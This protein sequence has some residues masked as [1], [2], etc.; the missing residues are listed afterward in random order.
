MNKAANENWFLLRSFFFLDQILY[1]KSQ[2]GNAGST[3]FREKPFSPLEPWKIHGTTLQFSFY[4]I[5]RGILRYRNNGCLHTSPSPP[6]SKASHIYISYF[7]F[8]LHSLESVRYIPFYVTT[9]KTQKWI[10]ISGIRQI[11]PYNWNLT[12]Q[13]LPKPPSA[14]K[15]L[16]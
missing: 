2:G 9:Q 15:K 12:N 8:P 6:A 11:C 1:S 16:L 4:S 7:H 5:N 10:S 14:K 3:L 13:M